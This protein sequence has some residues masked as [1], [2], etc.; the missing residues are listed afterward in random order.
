LVRRNIITSLPLEKCSRL[1]IYAPA[2]TS[3]Q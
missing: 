3:S 2:I 1:A